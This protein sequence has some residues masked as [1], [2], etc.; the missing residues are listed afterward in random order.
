MHLGN[1]QQQQER[2][3]CPEAKDINGQSLRADLPGLSAKRIVIEL[4]WYGSNPEG[5][6]LDNEDTES[7]RIP[8]NTSVT[9]WIPFLTFSSIHSENT[10]RTVE[11]YRM[12]VV[13]LHSSVRR[14]SILELKES[15]AIAD[16]VSILMDAHCD[17]GFRG[18]IFHG[19]ESMPNTL[20][21]YATAQDV[22]GVDKKALLGHK[23]L[24]LSSIQKSSNSYSELQD[25]IW[26]VQLQEW[27][28]ECSPNTSQ[29]WFLPSSSIS[30]DK[31]SSSFYTASSDLV[32]VILSTN[33]SFSPQVQ[34]PQ[35]TAA[36]LHPSA[37][38]SMNAY[39]KKQL[40]PIPRWLKWS[41]TEVPIQLKYRP[42][43]REERSL[44]RNYRTWYATEYA[45]QKEY[46]LY[47]AKL[48]N[49]RI[50]KS[51]QSDEAPEAAF[52]CSTYSSEGST[53]HRLISPSR[54][55]SSLHLTPE[56]DG[57]NVI[58]KESAKLMPRNE[59]DR[60]TWRQNISS[61]H[62]AEDTAG[63]IKASRFELMLIH[64]QHTRLGINTSI[65]IKQ[66]A[67]N[68]RLS[69]SDPESRRGEVEK[70]ADRT[71][72]PPYKARPA[73]SPSPKSIF[74]R[75]GI[76]AIAAPSIIASRVGLTRSIR[77]E[78]RCHTSKRACPTG[79]R[80]LPSPSTSYR[81]THES[82]MDPAKFP[83][84]SIYMTFVIVHGRRQQP[85]LVQTG[86]IMPAVRR[87]STSR[88]F[89]GEHQTLGRYYLSWA[90]YSTLPPE[91]ICDQYLP[92]GYVSRFG[93]WSHWRKGHRARDVWNFGMEKGTRKG[94]TSPA[95]TVL[96][97]RLQRARG[98]G[99]LGAVHPFSA[100]GTQ[101]WR[102]R[103]KA[104][105]GS[106]PYTGLPF[107]PIAQPRNWWP[108]E[109]SPESGDWQAPSEIHQRAVPRV[110]VLLLL[111]LP[112]GTSREL[113]GVGT[114]WL[115]STCH[116]GEFEEQ[117]FSVLGKRTQT[118]RSIPTRRNMHEKKAM[119]I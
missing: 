98:Q 92:D 109:L 100:T 115:R 82:N 96:T 9:W 31:I 43:T 59:A 4:E 35:T 70:T 40:F 93:C 46:G 64:W 80:P 8:Q 19:A 52:L 24:L 58:P 116:I 6:F 34:V 3:S 85:E 95:T 105:P 88:W 37:P 61:A 30:N 14:C 50:A 44:I 102:T 79:S 113:L 106:Q 65:S 29:A 68:I 99:D 13:S 23:P 72:R 75:G 114:N 108:P 83:P 110:P 17:V 86:K 89:L 63:L 48:R 78:A 51:N 20:M 81:T 56:S 36:L 53:S 1:S 90:A 12:Q 28:P 15:E 62:Q 25:P 104:V 49:N 60:S 112:M 10:T 111:L 118:Q 27:K 55:T 101:T 73:T 11:T 26:Y 21:E 45:R 103:G 16:G 7:D 5:M 97:Q 2:E 38:E 54:L 47:E 18:V 33:S 42:F 41:L 74:S 91:Q 84:A 22:E 66:T 94:K 87:F 107:D 76:S 69:A 119:K 39:V 57:R 117:P 77:F 67:V 71:T 32:T